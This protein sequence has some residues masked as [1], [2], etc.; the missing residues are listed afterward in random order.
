MPSTSPTQIDV[1]I[2]SIVKRLKED[3]AAPGEKQ[4]AEPSASDLMAELRPAADEAILLN[5][6]AEEVEL[7]AQLRTLERRLVKRVDS[8]MYDAKAALAVARVLREVA[9][10]DSAVTRKI[11][12]ALVGASLLRARRRFIEQGGYPDEV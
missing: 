7:V 12:E 6:A 3:P 1:A 8:V 10:V 11:K 4:D 9:A 5:L 2:P